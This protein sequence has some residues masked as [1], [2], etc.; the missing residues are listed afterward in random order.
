MSKSD[1]LVESVNEW[2]AKHAE[3]SLNLKAVDDLL[4]K[5]A[6]NGRKI[7]EA[8]AQLLAVQEQGK[9]LRGDLST[10]F[11]AAKAQRKAAKAGKADAATAGSRAAPKAKAEAK[12]GAAPAA[13]AKTAAKPAA[14]ASPAPAKKTPE[15]AK[16]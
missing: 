14:K 4:K 5:L 1:K 11:A 8:K 2:R 12:P 13:K 6:L 15:P 3:E 7:E 16:N 10:A 9:A